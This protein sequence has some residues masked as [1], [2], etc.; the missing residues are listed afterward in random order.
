MFELRRARYTMYLHAFGEEHPVFWLAIFR[1]QVQGP[2]YLDAHSA[3][4][5][6]CAHD[7][8]HLVGVAMV[9]AEF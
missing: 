8:R 5:A 3:Q 2:T 1:G 7:C 9:F 6:Q 4:V